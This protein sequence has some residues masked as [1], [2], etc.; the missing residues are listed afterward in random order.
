MSEPRHLRALQALELAIR[1]G[2]LK[3]A[4]E[5]LGITPAAA[6][7]RIRALE[8]Y[9]GTELLLRGR[10]G[11]RP[12]AAAQHALPELRVAFAA[13]AR[14]AD[15]LDF[16]RVAEIHIVADPDWTELWL[17]PRL[18]AFREAHPA[19]RF[20]INGE[21]DVPLRLGAPDLRVE[22]SDEP[23]GTALFT[24]VLVPVT[25]P[26]NLRRIG[27]GDGALE[28]EGLPLIHLQA[29][30]AAIERPGWPQWIARYGLRREGAD[31]GVRY[32]HARVALEAVRG[33][34]G[35]LICGLALSRA[36]LDQGSAVLPF[37]AARSLAAPWPYRMVLRDEAHASAQLR[38][39][40]DWLVEQARETTAWIDG[41][42][43]GG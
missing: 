20:C 37:P 8:D 14:V 10:S 26:D 31:R 21:G 33:N 11:L 6:G 18:P 38:R 34:V 29:Q 40:A 13:L 22:Y 42:V 36:D 12:T 1:L 39:F 3:S 27:Q 25:G 23:G 16:Q 7:Q 43:A 5:C 15:K 9:L 28:L 19:I 32:R 17:A 35:F 24:D 4:A 41:K 30:G 2:S